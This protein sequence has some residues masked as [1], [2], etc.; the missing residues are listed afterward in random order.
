ML[1]EKLQQLEQKK[2]EQET[3]KALSD[4]TSKIGK[5]NTHKKL[6]NP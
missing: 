5:K 3:N 2:K 4:I 1:E 6:R